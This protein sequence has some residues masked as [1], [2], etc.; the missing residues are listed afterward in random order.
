MTQGMHLTPIGGGHVLL[1][2]GA[3]LDPS[4]PDAYLVGVLEVLQAHHAAR[5]IYDLKNVPLLEGVYYRW[6]LALHAACRI[7][8]IQLVTVNMQPEAAYALS[9]LITA[10][11]PF[12]CALDV[13]HVRRIVERAAQAPEAEPAECGAPEDGDAVA[14]TQDRAGFPVH[15]VPE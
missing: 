12:V 3:G 4:D 11:P 6:L 8:G 9:Q 1:E 15:E 14:D 2:P 5:L 10:P 7:S 13:D